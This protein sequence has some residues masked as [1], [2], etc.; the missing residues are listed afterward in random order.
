MPRRHER[1]RLERE[2]PDEVQEQ[3]DDGE[4]ERDAEAEQRQRDERQ[5]ALDRRQRDDA[6]AADGEQELQ[7]AARCEVGEDRAGDEQHQRGGRG[8]PRRT[9]LLAVQRRGDERAELVEPDRRRDDD[10][11]DERDP[12]RDRELLE[13]AER[14]EVALRAGRSAASLATSVWQ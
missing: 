13:G 9:L 5:V 14:V 2:Q 8:T 7:A 11:G 10:A 6:V 1:I 4:Q 3:H 12:Q